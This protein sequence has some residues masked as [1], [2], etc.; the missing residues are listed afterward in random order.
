MET[1]LGAPVAVVW[2][3]PDAAYAHMSLIGMNRRDA[4]E[5]L[6]GLANELD[7]Q[8]RSKQEPTSDFT[9][10]LS[11][12]HAEAVSATAVAGESEEYR[13]GW[14]QAMTA[15]ET[16]ASTYEPAFAYRANAG[17]SGWIDTDVVNLPSMHRMGFD[18]ERRAVGPWESVPRGASD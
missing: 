3:H 1:I 14:D 11:S 5:A 8:P 18:V 13:C 15:V 17:H 4:A 16:I 10:V 2:I 6:R 7:P 9:A 12:I